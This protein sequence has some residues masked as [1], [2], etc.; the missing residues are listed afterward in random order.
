M[1]LLLLL[2]LLLNTSITLPIGL[3]VTEFS[4]FFGLID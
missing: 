1:L 4:F 2:L 3:A